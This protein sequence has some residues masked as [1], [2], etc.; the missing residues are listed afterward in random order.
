MFLERLNK[1]PTSGFATS[2][3]AYSA[4]WHYQVKR[5]TYFC[6]MF[7]R[8]VLSTW[9]AGFG[10]KHWRNNGWWYFN[11]LM[12]ITALLRLI[13][14][15]RLFA[16]GKPM[17]WRLL[18]SEATSLILQHMHPNLKTNLAM[19]QNENSGPPQLLFLLPKKDFRFFWVAIFDPQPPEIPRELLC[20]FGGILRLQ[21]ASFL[22]DQSVSVCVRVWSS[23]GSCRLWMTR[24]VIWPRPKKLHIYAQTV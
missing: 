6:A 7:E 16:T 21:T 1:P 9:W 18:K 2:G 24:Q 20:P 5:C 4:Y 12:A 14:C 3:F 15:L 13:L 10:M 17:L 11:W 8:L 22:E 23:A 19:G